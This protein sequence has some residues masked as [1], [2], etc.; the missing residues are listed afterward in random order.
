[1]SG[2]PMNWFSDHASA[3]DLHIKILGEH[4]IKNIEHYDSD[5]THCADV[6]A[7]FNQAAHLVGSNLKVIH[8]VSESPA[9]RAFFSALQYAATFLNPF[10]VVFEGRDSDIL[11]TIKTRRKAAIP[12]LAEDPYSPI[13]LTLQAAVKGERVRLDSLAWREV[14]GPLV[15]L[16]V[17][18]FKHHGSEERFSGDRKR[19]RKMGLLGIETL[20][21]SGTEIFHGPTMAGA[22]AF[23][24]LCKKLSIGTNSGAT[25]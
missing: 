6:M 9:E 19:D 12:I 23:L 24:T 3:E 8:D 25:C 17:D 5:R 15:A 1:M 20:R 13:I 4:F 14:D 2:V 7:K 16:E 10:S 18:G 11:G 22:D 21:Y